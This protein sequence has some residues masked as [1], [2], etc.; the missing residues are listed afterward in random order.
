MR[1]T[2][3]IDLP[4]VDLSGS[5]NIA[6]GGAVNLT[7]AVMAAGGFRSSGT[8]FDNTSGPVNTSGSPI[9]ISHS[10]AV[11][12]GTINAGSGTISLSGS[13]IN[14]GTF[15]GSS[16]TINAGTIG[17]TAKPTADV[18]SLTVTL[19]SEVGDV[20]GILMRGPALTTPTPAENIIAPVAV[21]IEG[22]FTYL[23]SEQQDIVGALA[24]LST[25]FTEQEQLDK[26][27]RASAE[28]Q[29]FMTPPLELYIEMDEEEE[30]I[31][32]PFPD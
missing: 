4:G 22:L 20:S 11:T 3:A 25:L 31:F 24:A 30:A 26:L 13:T 1:D 12:L 14:G 21:I 16:A 27:L 8:T 10:G 29:F 15:S 9:V 17:L 6:S 32:L 5:L 23:P 7:G 18:T 19:S 28:A 2:S